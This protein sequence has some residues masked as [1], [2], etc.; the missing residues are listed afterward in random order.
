MEKME[1]PG[2]SLLYHG[3]KGEALPFPWGEF[4]G[5]MKAGICRGGSSYPIPF[6]LPV[7]PVQRS[8]GF[9]RMTK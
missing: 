1:L 2:T 8:D 3:T 6:N 5:L 4:Q 9:W 7:W